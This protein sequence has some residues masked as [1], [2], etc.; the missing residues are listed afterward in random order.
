MD[1]V[2]GMLIGLVGKS[3]ASPCGVAAVPGVAGEV[4]GVGGA[5]ELPAEGAVPVE[6]WVDGTPLDGAGLA[7]AEP[8]DPVAA[9]EAGAEGLTIC[10]DPTTADP[11]TAEPAT[12]DPH[13]ASS[14][15]DTANATTATTLRF[16]E[17]APESGRP[18]D[19]PRCR[20]P[21]R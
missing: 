5:S 2:A 21:R 18:G 4:V 14:T 19:L 10:V 16:M 7:E 3:S 11:T 12:V 6:G 20:C 9:P 17:C 8:G 15:D 1:G 13:A